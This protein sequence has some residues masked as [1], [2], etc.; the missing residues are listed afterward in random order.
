MS[1]CVVPVCPAAVPGSCN[2]TQWVGVCEFV[3]AI[4]RLCE[5]LTARGHVEASKLAYTDLLDMLD[6]RGL[7]GSAS[8][9]E[10]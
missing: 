2:S 4:G 6:H 5:H 9:G 3:H 10:T 1:C 7:V 8:S